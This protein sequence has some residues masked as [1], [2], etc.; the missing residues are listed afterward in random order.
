MTRLQS[1]SCMDQLSISIQRQNG[2][3]HEPATFV[4]VTVNTNIYDMLG[5][6]V[7]NFHANQFL[8]T[9]IFSDRQYAMLLFSHILMI[10]CSWFGLLIII[11]SVSRT[12]LTALQALL[13]LNIIYL[14]NALEPLLCSNWSDFEILEKSSLYG[15][16]YS[17]LQ[18]DHLKLCKLIK[19]VHVKY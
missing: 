12:L 15:L 17:Q 16:T 1:P 2:L 10:I 6:Y 3:E 8:T 18:F 14:S 7:V 9:V 13:Q 4:S 5:F 19:H 11:L